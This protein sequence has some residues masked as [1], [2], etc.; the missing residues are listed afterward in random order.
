M[1]RDNEIILDLVRAIRLILQFTEDL[2]FNT[3][4]TDLKTQSSVLYK[5]VIIGEAVNRLSPEF[6]KTYPQIPINAI[7]GM[8]NR[9]VHQYKEVDIA[10]L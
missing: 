1:N 3:F 7:R 4:S 10:I 2:D 6:A 9:V 5:I 8:R